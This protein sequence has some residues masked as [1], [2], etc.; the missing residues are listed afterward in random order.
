[1]SADHCQQIISYNLP[2]LVRLL[3]DID[4]EQLAQEDSVECNAIYKNCLNFAIMRLQQYRLPLNRPDS[5]LN[6]LAD[7]V[8]RF[9]CENLKD[10]GETVKMLAHILIDDQYCSEHLKWMLLDFMLSVNYR[11]FSTARIN[12]EA[13]LR[14]KCKLLESLA[15]IYNRAAPEK[16]K[17]VAD[18]Q[19]S[20]YLESESPAE[21]EVDCLA[22]VQELSLDLELESPPDSAPS[23]RTAE[24]SRR[25]ELDAMESFSRALNELH[26][27]L[28][29]RVARGGFARNYGEHLLRQLPV[30]TQSAELPHGEEALMLREMICMFFAPQD[31]RNF[32]LVN[33]LLQLRATAF[34]SHLCNKQIEQLLKRIQYMQQLHI[35]IECYET[36]HCHGDRLE[37]LLALTTA[38]RRLL[39]PVVESLTYFEQRLS[40]G[41]ALQSVQSLLHAT[42]GSCQRL[43]LV[44]T[45]VAESF[46]QQ[47]WQL[48]IAAHTRCQRI[49]GSL[50]ALTSES[51]QTDALG[52]RACAAALLLHVLR[53]Y[54]QYLD[55]WWQLGVFNDWHD[56]FP[57]MRLEVSGRTEYVMRAE[58]DEELSLQSIH[59]IINQHVAACGIPLAFLHDSKRLADFVGTHKA[60]LKEPLHHALVNALLLQLQPYQVVTLTKLP[61]VPDIFRQMK[62]NPDEQL[63]SLYYLYY[64]ETLA[65]FKQ[66]SNCGIDKLLKQFQLCATYAPLDELICLSLERLL[67]QRTLLLNSYVLHLLRVQLQIDAVL[68]HL[69][70]IFLL[71]DFETYAA[72]WQQLLDQL[73]QGAFT[74]VAAQLQLI[75]DSHNP[76][77]GYP[78]SVQLP[79]AELQQLRIVFNCDPALGWIITESQLG[80]YNAAFRLLLQVRVAVRRLRQLPD[81]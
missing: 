60:L 73:E 36:P 43:Q 56:E 23:S 17:S 26:D 77:L 10:L 27:S 35:Y 2:L 12:M 8:D 40:S 70:S 28:A 3:L 64:K 78:F 61:P 76:R 50:L 22:D 58:D 31:C 9:Y 66:P 29:T 41:R 11:A 62:A 37:T 21:E 5:I 47:P 69:R 57:A 52:A 32:E 49:L 1:R 20:Q 65:D 19:M 34:S 6:N 48:E 25:T 39:K 18:Y 15:S 80:Q 44:W 7:F 79:G 13:M 63:R 75:I 45:V 16:P 68:E 51:G 67:E 38:L 74:E 14:I 30:A 4:E 71:L 53:V 81:F 24:C 42:N 72:Q 46:V 59:L 55:N 54:C 33:N